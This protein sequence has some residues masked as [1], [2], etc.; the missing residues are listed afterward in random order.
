MGGAAFRLLCRTH[1]FTDEFPDWDLPLQKYFKKFSLERSLI[2]GAIRTA[3]GAGI[4]A[5]SFTFDPFYSRR[6]FLMAS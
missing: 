4:L 1:Q 2:G 5:I 6:L 3:L